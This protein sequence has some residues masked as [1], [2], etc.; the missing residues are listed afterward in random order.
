MQTDEAPLPPQ[1]DEAPAVIAERETGV[2]TALVKTAIDNA[3]IGLSNMLAENYVLQGHDIEDDD[4]FWEY[5]RHLYNNNELDRLTD[6]DKRFG[7]RLT[8]DICNMQ[9][10]EKRKSA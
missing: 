7:Q 10:E 5:N 8:M 6:E 3:R 2:D 1:I 9:R 4:E